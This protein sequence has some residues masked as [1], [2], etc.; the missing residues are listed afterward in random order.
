MTCTGT[1]TYMGEMTSPNDCAGLIALGAN[2]SLEDCQAMPLFAY[3]QFDIGGNLAWR[4]YVV[5]TDD[6]YELSLVHIWGDEN[7][8]F[9]PDINGPMLFLHGFFTDGL[10][11]FDI[12]DPDDIGL[13]SQMWVASYDVWIA[14]KRGTYYSQGHTDPSNYDAD[15]T[16]DPTAYCNYW[17]FTYDQIGLY[18]IPAF[19]SAIMEI[20]RDSGEGLYCDKVNIVTHTTGAAELMVTL[21]EYPSEAAA[22]FIESIVN[23]SPC[24]IPTIESVLAMIGQTSPDRRRIL[25]VTID[26]DS[27][28]EEDEDSEDERESR[29]LKREGNSKRRSLSGSGSG[30]PN[31]ISKQA[32][33]NTLKYIRSLLTYE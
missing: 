28:F 7:G 21:N 19:L 23:L 9:S 32:L 11:W 26:A 6:G 27:D 15:A 5:T 8:N 3:A 20:R 24:L 16:G 22:W 33:Y 29:S 1:T 14:F 13:T 30:S 12:N 25:N 31:K 18:D 10:A 17:D 2:V 4:R